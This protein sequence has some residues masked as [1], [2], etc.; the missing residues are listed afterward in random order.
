MSEC[1]PTR[2]HRVYR[3]LSLEYWLDI[4]WIWGY[5]YQR[6]SSMH[7][8]NKFQPHR[9]RT[10]L[11]NLSRSFCF[12]THPWPWN[13]V[14]SLGLVYLYVEINR[15]YHPIKFWTTSVHKRPNTCQR[16]N[17]WAFHS[18]IKLECSAWT[19]S[20]YQISSRRGEIKSMQRN[21]VNRF[22]FPLVLWLPA[23]VKASESDMDWQKYVVS[24][25]MVGMKNVSWKVCV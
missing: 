15:R 3:I 13:K 4:N 1:K 22:C 20:T 8:Y 23:K 11:V 16:S 18:N 12:L 14:K 10:L 24:R 21:E 17:F 25:S 9:L 19:S 7:Q 6:V 2:R 5:R